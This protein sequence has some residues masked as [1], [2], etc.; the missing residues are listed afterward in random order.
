M[1]ELSAYSSGQ[2]SELRQVVGGVG[3]SYVPSGVGQPQ[4]HES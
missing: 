4:T 2:R 1:K 3:L